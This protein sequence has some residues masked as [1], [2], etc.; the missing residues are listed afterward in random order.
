VA[1]L[2]RKQ[3]FHILWREEQWKLYSVVGEKPR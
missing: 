2:A 3:G 1:R